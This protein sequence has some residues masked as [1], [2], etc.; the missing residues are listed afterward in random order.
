MAA[1]S[2]PSSRERLKRTT[3]CAEVHDHLAKGA[4]RHARSTKHQ[5]AVPI[6]MHILGSPRGGPEPND[7]C[8]CRVIEPARLREPQISSKLLTPE[9]P[10]SV[11]SPQCA[12]SQ[13]RATHHHVLAP[14]GP[15]DVRHQASKLKPNAR[16]R[17]HAKKAAATRPTA[18]VESKR[19]ARSIHITH[20]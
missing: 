12:Q 11:A 6:P 7:T 18:K 3:T 10:L 5:H 20:T 14:G 13:C 15:R 16:P 17:Q 1:S 4:K 8:S 2:S 9:A 19:M